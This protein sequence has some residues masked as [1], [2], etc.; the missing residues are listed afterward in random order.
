MKQLLLLGV[1]ALLFPCTYNTDKSKAKLPC[2]ELTELKD[3]LQSIKSSDQKYRRLATEMRQQNQGERTQEEVALWNL[4]MEID[5]L[6]MVKIEEIINCHGY[7]GK[8]LVGEDLKSVAALVIIHNPRDQ[9]KYLDLLWQEGQKGSVDKR[10]VAVLEDRIL[11]LNGEPQIYG[12][13]MKYNTV[14]F[15]ETGDAMTKLKIWKIKDLNQI[16]SRREEVG[17]Y[18]FKLQCELQGID[19]SQFDQYVHE[20]NKFDFE[21]Q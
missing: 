7:P 17:L 4:Q 1:F 16:D 12:T 15:N 5:S 8:E 6:N 20:E 13:A 3:E 10:E 14:G 18:S 9:E 2:I 21:W 11:M 19:L